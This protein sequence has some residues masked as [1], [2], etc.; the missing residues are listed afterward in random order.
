MS[1]KLD[2]YTIVIDGDNKKL[3]LAA[4][5][6]VGDL[7]KVDRAAKGAN[8][9][10]GR[11]STGLRQASTNAA[12]F[13]GPLG[14]VSGRLGAMSSMLGSVNP[15]MVGFGVAV[16]G[17][18][19]FMASA[20]KEHDQLALRNK[21]Q[22]AVLK[23]TGYAAGFAAH[24]LDAMAKSV[25]LNT[26]ASV[27]GIKDTQNVLL[28]FK[29]VSESSFRSAISLSQDMAAVMGT[30]SKSAALQL[31]KALESPTE[32]ISALKKAGVSFTQ[33]QRD[34]IREMEESGRV[35]DAQ[36][37]I[38]ETL[39]NQIGGAGQGE[40]G[41]LSGAVDTL[42]Q[43]WQTLK[44]VVAEDSGAAAGMQNLAN[45]MADILDRINH[46]LAP[47]DDSRLAQLWVESQELRNSLASLADGSDRSFLSYIVG[48]DSESLRLNS[49]LSIVNK[50]IAEIEA[51]KKERQAAEEV[52]NSAAIA[53]EKARSA[54]LLSEKKAIEDKKTAITQAKYAADL[55]AMDTQFAGETQKVSAQYKANIKRIEAWQLN[56]QEVK[57]RGFETMAELQESYRLLADEKRTADLAAVAEKEVAAEEARTAKA[58]EESEKRAKN[59]AA[60]QKQALQSV[61]TASGQFLNLLESNGQKQSAVFKLLFAAQQAAQIPMTIANAEAA[62]SATV[63]HDAPMMG[64]SALTTGNIIRASGYA[65]AGIIAGQAI[66]GAF[67]N[68][69]IVGGNSYT[70]D[71]LTA[72]VNSSEMILNRPQQK[73]LFD[74]ANG[75]GGGGGGVV[76]NVIEDA[77]KAGQTSRE[78]GLTQED[79]INIYVSNVTQAGAAA[80]INEQVYGLERVGR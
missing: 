78:S 54:E 39:K 61:L 58:K 71:N 13:Q 38:L 1:G 29:G 65:S 40:A 43:N 28:T 77:S 5:K 16:S 70:G 9:G 24:E 56:E 55:T 11:L 30:D 76:V 10:V 68:G 19:L 8:G 57:A 66:A 18:T 2:R 35:T 44:T 42:A 48:T 72:F 49:S 51:R 34:M 63:A 26:L 22:E 69:G 75:S 45:G 60:A 46:A 80:Q 6:T 20:I 4:R 64:V 59:E 23:S 73:Q 79:V 53:N 31:G 74:M 3:E 27:E 37:F 7:G 12:V 62:A 67:E 50:E 41:T 32:G 36:T 14:G 25:A 52:A 15:A 33:S 47:D 17:V 21:K